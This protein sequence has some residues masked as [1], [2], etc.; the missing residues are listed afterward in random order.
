MN[1]G[2][3]RVS[4]NDQNLDLQMDALKAE[5]CEKIYFDKISGSTTT[6]P[7]FDEMKNHLRKGDTVVVFKLDRLGRSLKHLIETI[8]EFN[9][10]GVSFKSINDPVDTTSSQG[11]LIFNIFAS[12][13]E[14][15]RDIIRDRTMAGLK[16]ARARGRIGGRPKGLSE[17]AENKARI[18]E[19]LYNE[20]RLSANQIAKNQ[21]ISKATLYKYLRHRGVEIGTYKKAS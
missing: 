20:G 12:L 10:S 4:T 15:E 13:A 18:C 2:Y 1:I 21:G 5:G 19:S 9:D 6:R 8:S 14:F 3:A 11:K 7:Q 16:S 17:E